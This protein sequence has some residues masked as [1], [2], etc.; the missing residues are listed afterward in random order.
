MAQNRKQSSSNNKDK[1]LSSFIS[2]FKVGL[3]SDRKRHEEHCLLMLTKEIYNLSGISKLNPISIINPQW[4]RSGTR[5]AKLSQINPIKYT[6]L[7]NIGSLRGADIK[8]LIT[9]TRSLAKT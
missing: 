6:V 8:P 4:L 1:F 7:A 3:N 2:L 9:G 5:M